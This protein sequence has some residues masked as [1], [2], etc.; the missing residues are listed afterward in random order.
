MMGFD[1]VIEAGS[2]GELRG[3]LDPSDGPA[4]L[5]AE[6][7]LV[8]G[9][10]ADLISEVCE[11]LPHCRVVFLAAHLDLDLLSDCMAAG[12]CGYLSEN[13]S[14]ETLQESLRLVAAGGTVFPAELASLLIVRRTLATGAGGAEP[15]QP[16]A[17]SDRELDVIRCVAGGASNKAIARELGI[18]QATVKVHLKRILSKT[19]FSNRTQ[20]AIW[21]LTHTLQSEIRGP[22]RTTPRDAAVELPSGNE[23]HNDRRCARVSGIEQHYKP[24]AAAQV[25]DLQHP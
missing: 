16:S 19:A 4:L 1:P 17:F 2:V 23:D 7:P 5:L 11:F 20:L 10:G 21:A 14:P 3:R 24:N 13:I 8:R 25:Q 6:L 18:A 12:A 9:G 15:P 22:R